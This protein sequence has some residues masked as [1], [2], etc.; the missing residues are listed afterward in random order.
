L[1]GRSNILVN[2]AIYIFVQE[3]TSAIGGTFIVM[4]VAAENKYFIPTSLL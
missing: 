1:L 2:A 3:T 4:V